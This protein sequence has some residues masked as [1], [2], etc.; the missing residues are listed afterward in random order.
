VSSMPKDQ[1]ENQSFSRLLPSLLRLTSFHLGFPGQ[2][3]ASNT[4]VVSPL[5]IRYISSTAKEQMVSRKASISG[6]VCVF[7]ATDFY[8][9]R[10]Q[11]THSWTECSLWS[12]C[13][14][15]VKCK[16]SLQIAFSLRKK[17]KKEEAMRCIQI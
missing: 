6:R 3:Y 2:K 15:L 9:Q 10:K 11:V 1:D 8:G 17:N 13:F 5:F 16:N 12:S 14:L 4:A 7:L